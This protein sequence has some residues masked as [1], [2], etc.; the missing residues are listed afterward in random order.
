[1]S[2]AVCVVLVF[3]LLMSKAELQKSDHRF[4]CKND[5]KVVI[6]HINQTTRE[7]AEK[8]CV[9]DINRADQALIMKYKGTK[10]PQW[11][12]IDVESLHE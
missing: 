4:Q 8:Y 10:I 6:A 7:I 5:G 3:S 9:G 11:S 1:M 2:F 12:F